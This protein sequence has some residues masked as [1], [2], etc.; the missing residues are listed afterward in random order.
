M[1]NVS[2][3]RLTAT[4]PNQVDAEEAVSFCIDRLYADNKHDVED[5][6]ADKLKYEELI[7]ALLL[8]PDEIRLNRY[9]YETSEEDV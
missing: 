8:A 9:E 3:E 5:E 7:S 4:R 6:L 2:T 1:R